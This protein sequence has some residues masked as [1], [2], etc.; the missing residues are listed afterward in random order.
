MEDGETNAGLTDHNFEQIRL[1]ETNLITSA[2]STTT[3]KRTSLSASS[4]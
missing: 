3:S 4:P 1:I 2:G